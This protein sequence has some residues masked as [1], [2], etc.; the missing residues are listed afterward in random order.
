MEKYYAPRS[1]GSRISSELRIPSSDYGVKYVM[2]MY[3]ISLIQKYLSDEIRQING[4]LET[5]KHATVKY[6]QVL[7][8]DKLVA[9]LVKN[10][11]IS[12]CGYR[13]GTHEIAISR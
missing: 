7:K 3:E 10:K 11:V 2:M 9:F 8:N 5:R 13:V 6:P 1:I 4:Y 12:R